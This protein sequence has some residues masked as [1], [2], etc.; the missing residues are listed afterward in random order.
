MGRTNLASESEAIMSKGKGGIVRNVRSL[1]N[2]RAANNLISNGT[3][4]AVGRGANARTVRAR[5][6]SNE[7]QT[8]QT[9]R[10]WAN[11]NS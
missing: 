8:S 11:R 4:R 9:V 6:R 3:I 5:A 10:R 1:P 2:T 7:S